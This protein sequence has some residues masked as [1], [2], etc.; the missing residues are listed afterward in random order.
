M[1]IRTQ[2]SQNQRNDKNNIFINA[3]T[4]QLMCICTQTFQTQ[5]K[6]T[7]THPS[8]PNLSEK[9]IET[10]RKLTDQITRS[11]HCN[12][13]LQCPEIHISNNCNYFQA[14]HMSAHCNA[15]PFHIRKYKGRG[16]AN[17][18]AFQKCLQRTARSTQPACPKTCRAK[19]KTPMHPS[20][21]IM[22]THT[23]AGFQI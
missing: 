3:G 17:P 15:E 4:I 13:A 18:A 20:K 2:C 8:P 12:N 9:H 7:S 1:C 22:S 11:W 19:T 5:A 23:T 10:Q 16:F 6:N 14:H 21:S